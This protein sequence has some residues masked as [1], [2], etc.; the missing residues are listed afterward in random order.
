[1]RAKSEFVELKRAVQGH[2]SSENQWNLTYWIDVLIDLVLSSRQKDTYTQMHTLLFLGTGFHDEMFTIS[3][4][5]LV[6]QH[7]SCV[8]ALRTCWQDRGCVNPN[9]TRTLS[10]LP[11]ISSAKTD[12]SAMSPW[13]PGSRSSMLTRQ[14]WQ[15]AVITSGWDFTF[16]R[17]NMINESVYYSGFFRILCSV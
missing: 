4:H 7:C 12:C 17:W 2:R 8:S 6:L 13:S 9:P 15:P 10:S 14:F 3:K 11:L 5:R 16:W 1:M